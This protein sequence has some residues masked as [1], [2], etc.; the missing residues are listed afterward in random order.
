MLSRLF[1]TLFLA[2][3]QKAELQ[4]HRQISHFNDKAQLQYTLPA[5]ASRTGSFSQRLHLADR[6]S[7]SMVSGDISE[8][9]K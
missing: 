2:A 1:R 4:F 6:N 9:W 3:L 8:D 7:K 5:S